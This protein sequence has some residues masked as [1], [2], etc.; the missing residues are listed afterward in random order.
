[1]KKFL[2]AMF[3]LTVVLIIALI[4]F[5]LTLDMNRYKDP[6]IEKV[7]GLIGRDVKINNL[8]L[9]V[10]PRTVIRM[11]G[12]SIKDRD[13]T[14]DERM[15]KAG[16]LEAVIKLLPLLRR[17]IQIESLIIKG[18]SVNMADLGVKPLPDFKL[19]VIEALFKN[20]SLYGPIH[21]EAKLSLFGRGRE[22]I[23]LKALLYPEIET[24]RPYLENVEIAA[25]LGKFDLVS[26]LNALGQTEMSR[27]FIGKELTGKLI[28]SSEE[29]YLD[30]EK[31]YDSNV[32]IEL[33]SGATDILPVGKGVSKIKLDA[34]LREGDLIIEK[35]TGLLGGG[36]FS[37]KGALEDFSSSQKINLDTTLRNIKVEEFLPEGSPGEPYL[38][39]ELGIEVEV[40][41]RGL[42]REEMVDTLMAKG[43][44]ELDKAVLNN[45]NI[46]RVSLDELNMLPGL[47]R[48]LKSRLP[49][50]Y[51]DLLRQDYTSFSPLKAQFD[52]KNGKLLFQDFL[53]ESDAF[54]I[55]GRCSLGLDGEVNINPLCSLPFSLRTSPYQE[56][57]PFLLIAFKTFANCL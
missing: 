31:I 34:A 29:V 11:N 25:D 53:I 16:S 27:Q 9:S 20:V 56:N 3:L 23:R 21:S 37:I 5:I 50:R 42:K 4:V 55:T 30:P 45:M 44:M 40:S 6:L 38:E 10:F 51:K 49:E 48:K 13:K 18:L 57:K 8:S 7:E 35:L 24:K 54:Y 1:M 2:T 33:S 43:V 12:V 22:N 32:Y 41:L 36:S 52:C 17:D 26:F 14:W 19:D 28:L 15:L 46:L 47:V 39:G